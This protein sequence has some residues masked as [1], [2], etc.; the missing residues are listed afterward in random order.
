MRLP[1]AFLYHLK[2]IR[3]RLLVPAL[4]LCTGAY[5]QWLNYPDPAIPRL[6]DGKPNLSAPAPHTG[7][8]PDLT[9]V[10]M[11]ERTTPD[12]IRRIFGSAFEAS[13]IGMEIG[14]QHK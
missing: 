1:A 7:G 2:M 6:K 8:K 14:T 4:L 12:E 11:H 5:A 10:W 9:G 13:P 3:C